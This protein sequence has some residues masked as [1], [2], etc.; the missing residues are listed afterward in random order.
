MSKIAKFE[1]ALQQAKSVK[2]LF[3]VPDVKERFI[4]NF[5][6][7]TGRKDGENRLEQEKFAY[8]EILNDKP[9]LR[10]AP[11]FSHFA[12]L[13]KA[14]TTGL[15][16]RDNKLYVQGIKK[17]N[18]VVALKVTSSP[19][20]KRE[21]IEMMKTVKNCP[22]PVLVMKGDVFIVDKRNHVV[23]EHYSTDKSADK[24]TLDNIVAAYQTINYKDGTS[25]DVVIA[26]DELMKARSKSKTKEGGPWIDWPGEMAKKV[27]TNRAYRLYHKYPDNVV[28]YDN[29]NESLA[30]EDSD[31]EV[32]PT[33]TIQ[34]DERPANVDE[35][36][37]VTPTENATKRNEPAKEDK[38]KSNKDEEDFLV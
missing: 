22:E 12:A 4:K 27:A 3:A 6:A 9:E 14:G 19:A 13:V 2:E 30:A 36:G 34:E 11:M 38:K 37:V 32:Q 23:R 25:V 20:G 17:D 7:V 31:Y 21:Q 18:V 24:V 35:D 29:D 28:I 8:L 1:Q 10:G 16:F 26:H 33:D 15:S 5:E